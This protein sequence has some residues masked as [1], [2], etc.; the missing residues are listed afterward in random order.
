MIPGISRHCHLSNPVIAGLSSEMRALHRLSLTGW[1]TPIL[2]VIF[3]GSSAVRRAGVRAAQKLT[4]IAA[5]P[6]G[7]PTTKNRR[8]HWPG[9]AVDRSRD[10]LGSRSESAKPTH[11]HLSLR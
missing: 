4:C 1:L 10:Q 8:G 6:S 5:L 9:M 3:P 11:A 2:R 7:F